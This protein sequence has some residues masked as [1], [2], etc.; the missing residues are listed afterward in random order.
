MDVSLWETRERRDL[1][2][3]SCRISQLSRFAERS[4]YTLRFSY[5]DGA[6]LLY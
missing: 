5:R 2:P 1:Q 3:S 4:V 6:I